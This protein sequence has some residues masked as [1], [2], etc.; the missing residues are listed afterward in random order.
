M[1]IFETAF[2]NR[3]TGGVGIYPNISRVFKSTAEDKMSDSGMSLTAEDP[4][5]RKRMTMRLSDIVH[6]GSAALHANTTTDHKVK[7]A[8]YG[9]LYKN[10]GLINHEHQLRI[11]ED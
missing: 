10:A 4:E 1:K 5:I 2:E 8:A 6:E 11:L 3:H 9:K 7:V